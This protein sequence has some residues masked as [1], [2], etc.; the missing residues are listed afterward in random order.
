MKWY[1]GDK[2]RE[3]ENVAVQYPDVIEVSKTSKDSIKR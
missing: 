3:R 2:E 1:R